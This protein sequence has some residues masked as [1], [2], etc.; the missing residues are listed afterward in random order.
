MARCVLAGLGVYVLRQGFQHLSYLQGPSGMH[1]A[2]WAW[3]VSL[4]LFL[5]VWAGLSVKLVFRNSGW[6]A[7][8]ADPARGPQVSPKWTAAGFRLVAVFSGLLILSL[9]TEFIA[10][11]V[12]FAVIAPKLLV[13]MVVF[14]YV[15]EIFLMSTAQWLHLAVDICTLVL[16]I[17]LAIGA[18]HYVRMQTRA[19]R[20]RDN[21]DTG[22]RGETQEILR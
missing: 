15:D 21:D 10:K 8:I 16:A 18:P 11:A 6:A 9:E 13:N 22:A 7:R 14:R 19:V 2:G 17:Y 3:A 20:A 5:A 1:I 4:V 12:V